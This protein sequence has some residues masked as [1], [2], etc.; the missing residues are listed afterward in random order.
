LDRLA[1]SHINGRG[2]HLR[3]INIVLTCSAIERLLFRD[4]SGRS[5]TA[6]LTTHR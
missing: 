1:D 4:L 5:N 2:N 6:E 3:E